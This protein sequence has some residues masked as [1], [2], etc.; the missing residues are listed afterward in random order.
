M[1]WCPGPPV[2]PAAPGTPVALVRIRLPL[3]RQI[4]FPIPD[5]RDDMLRGD[6]VEVGKTRGERTDR[7]ESYFLRE[8][9]ASKKSR[10]STP[11]KSKTTPRKPCNS[12][13]RESGARKFLSNAKDSDLTAMLKR[14]RETSGREK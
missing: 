2:A 7:S 1:L 10:R 6:V 14:L 9:A 5:H 8:D 11:V 3:L 4:P 12:G 13:S